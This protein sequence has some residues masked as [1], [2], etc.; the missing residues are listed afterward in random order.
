MHVSKNFEQGIFVL[1]ILATQFDHRPLKS[2]Q[3]S[4]VMQVSD[5]SLKKTLRKLVVA[6][7]IESTASKDGGFILKRTPEKISLLDVMQAIDAPLINYT[8]TRVAQSIFPD[9][10]HTKQSELIVQQALEKGGIAFGQALAQVKL[11][12]L[13]QTDSWSKGSIDWRQ[14]IS[15]GR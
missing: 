3:L 5:S 11:D 6:D 14:R 8:S 10:A 4:Q 2:G 13:L 12:Q 1:L 7:L 9:T 15:P